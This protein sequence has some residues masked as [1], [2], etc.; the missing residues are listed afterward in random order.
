M[1]IKGNRDFCDVMITGIHNT[2]CFL[3]ALRTENK[4]K[5]VNF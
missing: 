2:V 4:L 3:P 5:K 1:E